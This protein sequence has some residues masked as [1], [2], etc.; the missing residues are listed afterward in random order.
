MEVTKC[1]TAFIDISKDLLCYTAQPEPTASDQKCNH[2]LQNDM[3]ETVVNKSTTQVFEK[4]C[5]FCKESQRKVNQTQQ[6][7]ISCPLESCD[8]FMKNIK[9]NSDD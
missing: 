4:K 1:F 6:P 8:D 5:P 3:E 7:L 9:T 2:I